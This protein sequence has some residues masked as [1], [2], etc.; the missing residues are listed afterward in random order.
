MDMNQK[1][2]ANIV[3]II[4]VVVL[5]GTVGYFTLSKK[6]TPITT[7]PPTST[8]SPN[9]PQ[10]PPPTIIN[11][12]S[13][14][15]PPSATANWKIISGS[16]KSTNYQV[17]LPPDFKEKEVRASLDWHSKSFENNGY[18]F[19]ILIE[20]ITRLSSFTESPITG[21]LMQVADIL[22]NRNTYGSIIEQREIKVAGVQALLQDGYSLA[23]P[24]GF[25]LLR[26][27]LLAGDNFVVLTLESKQNDWAKVK[28]ETFV[29]G[30][31]T[32]N[33]RDLNNQ[34]ISTFKFTK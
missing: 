10:T 32:Q 2:F 31:L 24:G 34:I 25:V 12:T 33:F 16:Y 26:T 6:S 19:N 29:R 15:P 9:I 22:E 5:A 30:R 3:L 4:F 7:E 13:Q 27:L 23:D 17:K 20:P 18:Y 1:G 11:D 8:N 21:S 14:T 28:D